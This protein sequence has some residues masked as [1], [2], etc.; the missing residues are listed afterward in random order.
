MFVSRSWTTA[1]RMA[2]TSSSPMPGPSVSSFGRAASLPL[3]SRSI[4]TARYSV[5]SSWRTQSDFYLLLDPDICF[6]KPDTVHTLV[7]A[8]TEHDD[9]WA[10]HL[11]SRRTTAGKSGP[12]RRAAKQDVTEYRSQ[13]WVDR[14]KIY[15]HCPMN[16]EHM[17]GPSEPRGI[18]HGELDE[19][20]RKQPL[21]T[22]VGSAKPRCEPCCTLVRNTAA[23]RRVADRIGSSKTR[24]KVRV[25]TI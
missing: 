6:V 14:R 16:P 23:F 11:R 10:V 1:P 7:R 20:A 2:Q 22:L 18:N 3:S 9:V 25:S 13:K 4:H 15:L 19:E 8:I 12:T 24:L 17:A 21:M 5:S